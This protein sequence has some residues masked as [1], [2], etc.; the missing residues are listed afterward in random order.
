[1]AS[2]FTTAVYLAGVVFMLSRPRGAEHWTADL[3][4]AVVVAAWP[5]LVVAGFV[6]VVRGMVRRARAGR[7]RN[8]GNG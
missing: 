3:G 4:R 6:G 7:G 8:L 5:V 1:M 2:E